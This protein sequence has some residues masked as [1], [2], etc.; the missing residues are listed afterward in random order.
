MTDTQTNFPAD[1]LI[2]LDRSRPRSLRAQLERELRRA[3]TQGSLPPG[4]ALPPSRTLAA[5]LSVSRTLVVGA[6]EQLISEGYLEAQQGSGTRVRLNG[7]GQAAGPGDDGADGGDADGGGLYWPL[8][9]QRSGAPMPGSGLPDPALFPRT[10]WLRH[11]RDAVRAAPDGELLYPP[12]RG[13]L[14]L[15]TALASYLGRVRGVRTAPGQVVI[16]AGF[17]QGLAL[18]CR[19]LARRGVRAVAVEDPCF[20]LHRLIIED[21]G[22]R[23]VPVP[24]TP[25]GLDVARLGTLADVGAVLLSPAHSYPSGVVLSAGRRVALLEWA[26]TAGGIVIEDDYDAELRYD[27]T[28]VAS[29]QGMDPARVVYGGSASK[30]LSPAL[31]LGWLVVPASLTRDVIVAKALL[32]VGS[33]SLGQLTLARFIDSGGFAAHLRRVRPVYR[34][35]RDALLGALR[36]HLPQVPVDGEL[37]GLHLLLRVPAGWDLDAAADAGARR[38]LQLENASA[39]WAGRGAAPPAFL[40]GYGTSRPGAL[41]D[42]IEA[43]AAYAASIATARERPA[44]G[45]RA[46]R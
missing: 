37:A 42:G 19:V 35:R 27:R 1:L 32:D 45:A 6:Y 3:V 26:R 18:L 4:T 11:Y 16:C 12:P 25:D 31:R 5:E 30:V 33:E 34:A 8:P 38:G 23:A 44:S 39:H 22:L 20:Q 40:V 13:T 36:Q 9:P 10:E 7:L 41:V 15:R 24:V 28:P 14:G 21:A 29:L 43:L 2:D 17:S 46:R